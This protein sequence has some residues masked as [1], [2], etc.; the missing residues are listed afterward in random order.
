[1]EVTIFKDCIQL[2][3]QGIRSDRVPEKLWTEVC[4]IVQAPGIKSI[5]YEKKC[6]R[7]R[8]LSEEASQVAE[9]RREVKDKQKEKTYPSECKVPKNSKYR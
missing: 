1:M 7:A 3:I 9:K 5:P 6:K 2:Y 4:D 8:Q